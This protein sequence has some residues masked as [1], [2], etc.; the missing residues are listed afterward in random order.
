MTQFE[1]FKLCLKQVFGGES[2]LTHFNIEG[3]E[4]DTAEMVSGAVVNLRQY[5]ATG[6]WTKNS[7]QRFVMLNMCK[8]SE[9]IA[10]AYSAKSYKASSTRTLRT[11]GVHRLMKMIPLEYLFSLCNGNPD[12][13]HD[14]IMQRKACKYFAYLSGSNLTLSDF[15]VDYKTAL[16]LS[17]SDPQ[18][19]TLDECQSELKFVALHYAGYVDRMDSLDSGKLL[20]INSL[21]EQGMNAVIDESDASILLGLS[22]TVKQLTDW[23]SK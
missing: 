10:S 13:K 12:S 16:H 19:C 7:Y 2:F 18:K 15:S 23:Y 3:K 14:F 22:D 5:I 9:Q 17:V 6:S 11:D 4:Y 8:T 1:Q 21:L 20:Y